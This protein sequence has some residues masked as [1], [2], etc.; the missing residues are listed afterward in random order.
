MTTPINRFRAAVA[1][2]LGQALTP[3][4]AAAIE[5]ATWFQPPAHLPTFE[6]AEYRGYVIG[7]ERFTAAL[8]ELHQLHVLHW[9]ETEKHRHGLP[10]NPDYALMA[11]H[12]RAG[13]L[14]QFTV[15]RDGVLVGN[16]RM[17]LGVSAHS[18]T[19]FAVFP[20]RTREPAAEE[21]T[22][23]LHPEHRGGFLAVQLL[24]YA[25]RVLVALGMREIRADSKLINR[26]DVLMRRLGYQP[27]A[28]KFVKIIEGETHVC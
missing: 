28:L 4:L 19:P 23:F 17:Y 15:R 5:A 8:P 24:R 21:D 27:F 9:R 16:L 2:H 13:R 26:A 12:E 25:E 6:R 7:V 18:G 11:E 3:E 14:L 20:T 10:L 22:L 1:A